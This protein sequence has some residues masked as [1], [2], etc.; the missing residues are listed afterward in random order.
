MAI[1]YRGKSF[2][3]SW[4]DKAKINFGEPGCMLSTGVKGKM[5]L[6]PKA[7]ILGVLHHDENQKGKCTNYIPYL[8]ENYFLLCE[9]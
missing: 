7:S 8:T 6:V 5:I 4:D 3:L 1:M 2:L 9:T